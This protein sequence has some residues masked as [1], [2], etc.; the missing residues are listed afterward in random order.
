[1]RWLLALTLSSG[2]ATAGAGWSR[3][4]ERSLTRGLLIC[5]DRPY[6]RID[7][8]GGTE[9]ACKAVQVRTLEPAAV[10]LYCAPGFALDKAAAPAERGAFKFNL[11]LSPDQSQVWFSGGDLFGRSWQ[12]FSPADDALAAPDG[13]G[14]WLRRALPAG[15]GSSPL[16]APR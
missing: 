7:C 3:C 10:A 16:C 4:A 12:A 2:C 11:Q 6:A 8:V 9:G 14:R 5:D 13:S 1:M 15:P